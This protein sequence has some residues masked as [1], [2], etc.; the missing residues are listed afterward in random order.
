VFDIEMDHGGIGWRGVDRIG[1]VQDKERVCSCRCGNELSGSIKCWEV[2]EILRLSSI[3]LLYRVSYFNKLNLS[4][5]VL[6][7][8]RI[9]YNTSLLN[10]S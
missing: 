3:T 2:L 9:L 8:I 10:E 7:S 6:Y 1:L 4:L 5:F